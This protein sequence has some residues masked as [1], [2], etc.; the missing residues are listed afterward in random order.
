MKKVKM[1]GDLRRMAWEAMMV[2]PDGY[3]T[4]DKWRPANKILN[5][6]EEDFIKEGE[7]LSEEQLKQEYELFFDSGLFEVLKQ[8]TEN[9][10]PWNGA[11]LKRLAKLSEAFEKAEEID[12]K[13]EGVKSAS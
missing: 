11:A 4:P 12:L 7:K 1:A 3:K 6:L 5:V 9:N 10:V 13:K 2:N 8:I